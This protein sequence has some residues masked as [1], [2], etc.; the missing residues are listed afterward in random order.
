MTDFFN[1]AAAAIRSDDARGRRLRL[2]AALTVLLLLPLLYLGS[3]ARGLVVGDPTEYTVVANV[4][5]VAH[6]PGYAFLTLVGHLFQT[7]IPVGEIPWRMHLVGVTAA[8]VALLCLFGAVRSV[9]SLIRPNR[10]TLAA[11]LFGAL[12]VGA[13]INFWQHAIHANP[14]ILTAMFLA[15][16]LASLTAWFAAERRGERRNGWL[17]LFCLSVGFGVTHHPLT[18]FALPACVAFVLWIRPKILLDWR[19]LLTGTAFVLLGLAV[20]LYFPLRAPALA[21]TQ[22]PSDMDTLDGFL[23]LVLARGLRVNLFHFGLVDQ[24]ARLTVFWTLLRLQYGLPVIFLAALGFVWLLVSHR[25]VPSGPSLAPLALLYG[26]ALLL[27]TAFVINTVQDV[28]AYLLGPYLI[29]GW[30]G[31]FGLLGLL[32]WMQTRL[33]LGRN[34]G[35]VYALLLVGLFMLGPLLGTVRSGSLAPLAAYSEGDDYV[36]AVFDYFAGAGEGAVLLNDWERWTPLLY[37]QLVENRWPDERDVRP[38]LV[39]SNKPW[40]DHV[41]ENLPGGPVYLNGY[42]PEIPAAGFRLRP[43]GPFY[44]VVEPGDTSIP[45]DLTPTTVGIDALQIVGYALPQTEVAAGAYVPLT[46]ALRSPAGTDNFYVPVLH[47]GEMTLPFTTDSHLTTNLYQPGEVIVER[48]DFALPHALAA[49]TYPVTVRLQQLVEDMDAGVAL[50]LGDLT[51]T[52]APNV[53][54][55]ADL[56]ANFRQRVGLASATARDGL[57]RRVAPWD[58]PLYAAPGDVIDVTLEWRSL[59]PAEESYTVFVHLIDLANRPILSLDYTPLGGASPTHL[60]FPKWVPGQ[61][62]LDPYRMQL[63]ADLPPGQYLIEV[64]LYEMTGRRRLLMSDAAGNH[65]GDRYILGSV[66]VE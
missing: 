48:F 11:A 57:D 45:P 55:T 46:L 18:V 34:A 17:Y 58:E 6:P 51:V 9:G 21:G 44:Q 5:G 2:A 1:Q 52:E 61:Q 64:G 62:M 23:N 31:G 27:N 22:F 19:T 53:P 36:T 14:H 20:W 4:L 35:V 29:I 24:P 28:M 43:S 10:Y 41:Y 65:V 13:A 8:T 38:K 3:M 25:T 33:S 16:N 30:L 50:S 60:W 32:H 63:P 39:S 47:V 26:G 49:G 40:I 66:I 12:S 54:R 56:L 37:A 15:V 59:A 7:V 42:R